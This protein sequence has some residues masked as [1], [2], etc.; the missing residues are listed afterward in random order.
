MPFLP[1]FLIFLIWLA[2]ELRKHTRITQQERDAFWEREHNAD[3]VR[4]KDISS[5]DYIQIPFEE[6]P[7]TEHL[8]DSNIVKCHTELNQLK[9]EKILNLTGQSNT[10]L[11]L[12]YGPAN[13]EQLSQYDAN[14]TS[15]VSTIARWGKLLYEQHDFENAKKVLEYGISIGTDVSTNYTILGQIYLEEDCTEKIFDLLDKSE[16]IPSLMKNSIQT[17]LTNLIKS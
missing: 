1:I 7:F 9:E 16:D 6:L 17:S 11:K 3:N 13:L 4:R 12:T 2:Y 14:Y 5:L 8:T 15:L 10:D